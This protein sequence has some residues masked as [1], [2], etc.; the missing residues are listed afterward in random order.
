MPKHTTPILP[1]LPFQHKPLKTFEPQSSEQQQHHQTLVTAQIPQPRKKSPHWSESC[2]CE[3]SVVE[4]AMAKSADV[5]GSCSGN[6]HRSQKKNREL[7]LLEHQQKMNMPTWLLVGT[8]NSKGFLV[9]SSFPPIFRSLIC[10]QYQYFL[11]NCGACLEVEFE[12]E[13]RAPLDGMPKWV[14]SSMNPI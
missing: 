7:K 6:Q 10:I 13:W 5:S 3:Q 12:F 4:L 11:S 1:R 8:S 2:R 9:G 14:W